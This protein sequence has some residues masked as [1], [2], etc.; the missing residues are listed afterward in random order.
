MTCTFTYNINTEDLLNGL[1]IINPVE[2]KN[3]FYIKYINNLCF[4]ALRT[5]DHVH[6]RKSSL[7]LSIGHAI[8]IEQFFIIFKFFFK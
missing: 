1:I 7:F 3:I 6:D 2:I 4:L 8:N 5:V